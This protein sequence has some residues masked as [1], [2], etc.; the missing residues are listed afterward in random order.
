MSALDSMLSQY[1]QYRQNAPYS[2]ATVPSTPNRF[3]DVGGGEFNR[4]GGVGFGG[5]Q[6]PNS[7]FS[8]VNPPS[9][10][11]AA[12][13]STGT[14]PFGIGVPNL[15]PDELSKVTEGLSRLT[16]DLAGGGYKFTDVN[17]IG[18]MDF[19]G[20]DSRANQLAKSIYGI[21]GAAPTKPLGTRALNAL[22]GYSPSAGPSYNEK[23]GQ[24]YFGPFTFPGYNPLG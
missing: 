9:N 10:V 24:S 13:T 7:F 12:A 2:P 19:P 8:A 17:Y 20:S 14:S 1:N 15:T 6:S 18:G 22:P 4:G 5:S 11:T 3:Y 23:L 21:I 16:Y